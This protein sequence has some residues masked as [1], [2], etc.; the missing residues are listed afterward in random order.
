M[1]K[2]SPDYDKSQIK[3]YATPTL[4]YIMELLEAIAEELGVEIKE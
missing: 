4:C 2:R 1:K 3:R